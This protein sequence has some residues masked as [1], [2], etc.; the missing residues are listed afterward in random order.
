MPDN[1]LKKIGVAADAAH[2]VEI[3]A[4]DVAAIS[5]ALSDELYAAWN[6]REGGDEV[7][8][9]NAMVDARSMNGD[10]KAFFARLEEAFR[11]FKTASEWVGTGDPRD[12][13]PGEAR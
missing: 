7:G 11:K 9:Q 3:H 13:H 10:L 6:L 2:E 4:R 5:E 1:D 12:W 8:F